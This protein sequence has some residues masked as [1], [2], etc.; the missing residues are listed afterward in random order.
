[1]DGWGALTMLIKRQE[2]AKNRK[3]VL[4]KA[5]QEKKMSY[6]HVENKTEFGFPELST[7][8]LKQLKN[9]IRKEIKKQRIKSIISSLILLISIISIVYFIFLFKK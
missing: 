6:L 9:D 2:A 8:E 7:V 4:K 5:L 1:M 3:A